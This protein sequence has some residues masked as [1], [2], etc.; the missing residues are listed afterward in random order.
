MTEKPLNGQGIGQ[1]MTTA[2]TTST[3]RPSVLADHWLRALVESDL[4]P[5]REEEI[6]PEAQRD[7]F[8]ADEVRAPLM[9]IESLLA[10]LDDGDIVLPGD[11]LTKEQVRQALSALGT[12]SQIGDEAVDQNTYLNLEQ[13]RIK[14]LELKEAVRESV[15]GTLAAD[16]LSEALATEGIPSGTQ[17]SDPRQDVND[18]LIDSDDDEAT[19]WMEN[20]E[21][22][23]CQIIT[24]CLLQEDALDLAA[25]IE[26]AQQEEEEY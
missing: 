16:L 8:E 26:E 9:D 13:W 10:V 20:F 4:N 5:V 24:R 2:L 22:R 6:G 3:Q 19:E 21:Y 15:A 12:P 7:P 25:V 17:L 14:L 18:D 1:L 11:D 23:V